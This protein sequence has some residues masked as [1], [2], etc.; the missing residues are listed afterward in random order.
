[1][2][3]IRS[4]LNFVRKMKARL[5]DRLYTL[6]LPSGERVSYT[7]EDLLDALGASLAREAHPLRSALKLTEGYTGLEGLIRAL[8]DAYARLEGADKE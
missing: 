1:M 8:E 4:N 6:E 2:G 3:G 7:S 5:A